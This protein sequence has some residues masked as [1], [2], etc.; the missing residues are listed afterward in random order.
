MLFANL[1][2]GL[3]A[4]P[5]P[6]PG[7]GKTEAITGDAEDRCRDG[8][9]K[10]AIPEQVAGQ[11]QVA[12]VSL[13]GSPIAGLQPKDAEPERVEQA[14]NSLVIEIGK[15]VLGYRVTDE[16]AE[17]ADKRGN[18]APRIDGNREDNRSDQ[19]GIGEGKAENSP[20][21]RGPDGR[22]PAFGFVP[23]HAAGEQ[24]PQ[25]DS[26]QRQHRHQRRTEKPPQQKA[27]LAQRLGKQQ[28]IGVMLEFARC[29]R[30]DKGSDHQAGEQAHDRVEVLHIVGSV[31]EAVFQRAADLNVIG[32]GCGED[33]HSE[34]QGEHVDHETAEPIAQ[35]KTEEGGKHGESLMRMA[36][37]KLNSGLA[38]QTAHPQQ[39]AL[40]RAT[41]LQG[42]GG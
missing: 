4:A 37:R 35:L 20:E 39:R 34:D 32:L 13:G 38:G 24:D 12:G 6:A 41:C 11:G 26:Q 7:A 22:A 9:P 40:I 8:K 36:E 2:S 23:R 42:S 31:S 5:T 10:Q 3:L 18:R 16:Q 17:H 33:Q 21:V 1:G 27:Q 25:T 29:G 28:L 15:Q 30:V 19:Q 14:G